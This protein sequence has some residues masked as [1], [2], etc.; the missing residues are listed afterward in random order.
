[1]QCFS[2]SFLLLLF[3]MFFCSSTNTPHTSHIYKF[4]Y[5]STIFGKS[6]KYNFLKPSWKVPMIS[7]IQGHVSKTLSNFSTQRVI[8][9]YYNNLYRGKF[10]CH[11]RKICT[12]KSFPI[13]KFERRDFSKLHSYIIFCW[14][15]SSTKNNRPTTPKSQF[16]FVLLLGFCNSPK[17]LYNHNF[18]QGKPNF[19]QASMLFF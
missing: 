9:F 4:L 15:L 14:L 17:K 12:M 1:M 11:S 18:F 16:F 3:P 8:V 19:L 13:K 6:N 10:F 7:A 5:Q 2:S